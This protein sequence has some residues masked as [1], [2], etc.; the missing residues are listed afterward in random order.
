[1]I[2]TVFLLYKVPFCVLPSNKI[3]YSLSAPSCEIENRLP[4]VT[5]TDAD[6]K[7]YFLKDN[8]CKSKRTII[9]IMSSECKI[10]QKEIEV[11]KNVSSSRKL[12]LG[13]NIII[14]LVQD[15]PSHYRTLP[16]TQFSVYYISSKEVSYMYKPDSKIELP[17]VIITN[18]EGVVSAKYAGY[19]P[20]KT[21]KYFLYDIDQVLFGAS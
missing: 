9:F 8:L 7:T 11:L 17:V 18:K 5:F 10:C 12:P 6:G 15:T 1:M 4:D 20:Y 21:N 19:L 13:T 3:S 16:G 2:G 14:L